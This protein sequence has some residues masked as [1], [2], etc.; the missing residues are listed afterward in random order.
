MLGPRTIIQF[1]A[2]GI[3][4]NIGAIWNRRIVSDNLDPW[5]NSLSQPWWNPPNWV[6]GPVWVVLYTA[7][8]I[9]SFLAYREVSKSIEGWD[10][11]AYS[12]LALYLVQLAFNWAWV[13]IFFGL[14]SL[15]WVRNLQRPARTINF[16]HIHQSID[17]TWK[18]FDFVFQSF[19]EGLALLISAVLCGIVFFRIHRVA[20]CIFIPYVA[21]LIYASA[22]NY[23]L[24]S[25]NTWWYEVSVRV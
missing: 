13:P 21:W 6:F 2:A 1:V 8:G 11:E 10:R 16:L 12:A 9:A 20:G 23:A 17:N 18:L 19:I 14:H 3:L 4:P 5:F 22:L 15:K 25:L 24:Y 7:M